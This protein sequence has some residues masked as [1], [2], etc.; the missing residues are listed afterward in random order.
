MHI[1]SLIPCFHLSLIPCID[2]LWYHVCIL[3]CKMTFFPFSPFSKSG[4]HKS[5]FVSYTGSKRLGVKCAETLFSRQNASIY[6]LTKFWWQYL[7]GNCRWN[8]C[9]RGSRICRWREIPQTWWWSRAY[10][11]RGLHTFRWGVLLLTFATISPTLWQT[12]MLERRC[13]CNERIT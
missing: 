3:F 13:S 10:L 6:N 9:I 2:A 8:V 5:I 12:S 1:Q 4:Y 11:S 7:F